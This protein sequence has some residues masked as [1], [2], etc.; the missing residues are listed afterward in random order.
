M[1]DKDEALGKTDRSSKYQAMLEEYRD[2][3]PESRSSS[4]KTYARSSA[5]YGISDEI[6]REKKLKNDDAAQDIKL[7][8]QTL[9]RL[10]NFLA[11]ETVVIFC[12]AFLQATKLFH[13]ELDEWSFKL[14]T[15][16]TITQIT[17]MLLVA[18]SYLFPK[19]NP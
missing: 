6:A 18:V 15:T 1:V 19:K 11:A 10:F 9:D 5:S 7:K 8:K 4:Q 12:F 3:I 13:F 16:V 14:L 17:I 2:L